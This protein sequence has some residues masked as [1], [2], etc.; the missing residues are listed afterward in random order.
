MNKSLEKMLSKKN[1]TAL[2]SVLMAAAECVPF[3]KTGGLADV[4][5]ALGTELKRKGF[6]V[7]IILPFHRIAKEKYWDQVKHITSFSID[8]GWRSQYVGIE[9]LEY[10]GV[11]CY[12]IDNEYYFG[13]EVYKGGNMEGE[14]YAFFS[15]AVIESLPLIGFIPDILHVHDWHTAMIP[16]LLKTQYLDK[17]QGA[18]HSV[19]TLHNLGYQGKFD[20]GFVSDLL[21]IEDKYYNCNCLEH[22]GCANLLK[23]G[24]IFA[25][26]LTTVSPTYAGEIKTSYFG[27]GLD[28]ILNERSN[29]LTG[30]ING[31]DT[32]EFNPKTDRYIGQKYD[33]S[34]LDKKQKDKKAA[35]DELG[36][37][38]QNKAPLITM[39]SRLT[40][41]KGLDLIMHI[42]DELMGENIRMVVLGSGDSQYEDFFRYV[43]ERYRGKMTAVLKY[44]NALAHKLYAGSDF[45]LMPSKFEPCGISQLIA[46]RYGTLPI[47]RATGG[48]KDTVKPYNCYTGQGNGF[49]FDNY[50][51]HDMLNTI[52][53]ALSVYRDKKAYVLLQQNAMH[54]NVSFT[55][56]ALAYAA[57][58]IDLASPGDKDKK[59]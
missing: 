1:M 32:R 58:Y 49:S 6:D 56:S 31:I 40:Q 54:T 20:F 15:R 7:R 44:D 52:K 25:D 26:K 13:Y 45:L 42:F 19:L 21:D 14:Q 24:I 37:E 55:A 11:Q 2:P 57:L 16:M 34:A 46:M 4:V 23:G 17:P 28:G 33:S 3:A 8:L 39:I 22:Y 50:N 48:L 41:Q 47:V 53:Y 30:I 38:V 51:A 59:S 29:D 18:I 35:I 9:M 10:K 27:E 36:L 12:F 43:R 5:G